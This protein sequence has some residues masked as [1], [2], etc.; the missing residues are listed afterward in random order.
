MCMM[1]WRLYALIRL[2]ENLIVI[3]S[4]SKNFAC[5]QSDL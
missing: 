2:K 3:D 4:V 1:G 5:G